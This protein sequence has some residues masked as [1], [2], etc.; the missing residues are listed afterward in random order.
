MDTEHETFWNIFIEK[1]M[2]H[3]HLLPLYKSEASL[4]WWAGVPLLLPLVESTDPF[5]SIK[6]C[7]K[8]L[9]LGHRSTPAVSQGHVLLSLQLFGR[10]TAQFDNVFY[11]TNLSFYAWCVCLIFPAHLREYSEEY[12]ILPDDYT[13]YVS[14]HE[15]SGWCL[16]HFLFSVLF[17]SLSA[18]EWI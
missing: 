5:F 13:D 10:F 4:I 11:S 8:P 1:W 6:V 14:Q 7:A 16:M 3:I 2:M 9:H 17:K 18:T 12:N 15:G